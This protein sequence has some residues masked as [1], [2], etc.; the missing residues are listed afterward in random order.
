[1][2]AVAVCVYVVE[3]PGPKPTMYLYWVF[4]AAS[5]VKFTEPK[6]APEVKDISELKLQWRGHLL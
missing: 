4:V 2:L 3:D 5:L 1:M 6:A